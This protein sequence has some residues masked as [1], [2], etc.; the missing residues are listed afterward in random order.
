MAIDPHFLASTA[1]GQ[2]LRRANPLYRPLSFDPFA[3]HF[4][5]EP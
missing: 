2:F 4:L 3:L 5:N 1:A